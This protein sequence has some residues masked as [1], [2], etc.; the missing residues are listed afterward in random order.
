[1]NQ[2]YLMAQLPSLDAV[3]E[4]APLPIT[5]ERFCELCGRFLGKRAAEVLNA[6]TLLPRATGRATGV[7]LVDAW[8]SAERELRIALA[9]Q[10]AEKMRKPFSA[11][12][13]SISPKLLQVAKE[14]TE[15]EDPLEAELYL[16][17]HRLAFLETLRP[18]DAFSLSFVYYYGLKLKLLTR[19]KTFDT[20]KGEAAYQTIYDAILHTEN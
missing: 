2:Y 14:A 4:N 20:A 5:E 16:H 11:G 6:L 19:I 17:R 3:A 13:V 7:A 8:E 12:E 10:R 9:V 15:M 1:M 18:A